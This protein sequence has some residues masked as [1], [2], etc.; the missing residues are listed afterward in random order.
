MDLNNLGLFKLMSRKAGWLT[1]RQE[2]LA[3]NIA[4]ADTPEYKPNDLKPFSFRDAMVDQR[5]IKPAATDAGH[6]QG[7]LGAGGLNKEQQVRNPYETAP[8]G[9]AVVLEEQI[10]KVGQN[11]MDYQTITNLYRKQVALIKSAIRG[12][13]A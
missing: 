3:A 6:L 11:A 4:N 7:T 8:A 2:V 12:G 10:M 1:Q 13:G 9:N 5:R